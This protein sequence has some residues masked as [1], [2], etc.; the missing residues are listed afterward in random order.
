MLRAIQTGLGAVT[1]S[2]KRRHGVT[3]FAR[4]EGRRLDKRAV[5]EL[6]RESTG[7]L[8]LLVAQL[9]PNDFWPL[10]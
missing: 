10:P 2:S 8:E 9:Y 7:R 1:A 5:Y 4:Y 3:V 6:I